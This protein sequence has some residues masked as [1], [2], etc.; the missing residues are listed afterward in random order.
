MIGHWFASQYEDGYTYTYLFLLFQND[1]TRLCDL[2]RFFVAPP[3]SY[4]PKSPPTPAC[5]P[6]YAMPAS[7]VT[8]SKDFEP[9]GPDGKVKVKVGT[10]AFY[11]FNSH[12]IYLHV[13]PQK[14]DT[15]KSDTKD[16][17]LEI[18]DEEANMSVHSGSGGMFA[19]NPLTAIKNGAKKMGGK[20]AKGAKFVGGAAKRAGAAV[21]SGVKS[22]GAAVATVAK[23]AY[24]KAEKMA[25]A[26]VKVSNSS[27]ASSSTGPSCYSSEVDRDV[28]YFFQKFL[29]RTMDEVNGAI[30]NTKCSGN[31][32]LD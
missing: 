31:A 20:L 6:Q 2:R 12:K 5:R 11:H 29:Q 26:V 9:D 25:G 27:T 22:A 14:S 4:P 21:A 19:G 7:L 8:E 10:W 24:K 13:Q 1:S 3:P 28:K 32:R 16:Q 30:S 23:K 18:E 17:L 15:K